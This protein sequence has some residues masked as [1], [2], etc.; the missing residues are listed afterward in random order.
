MV[1]IANSRYARIRPDGTAPQGRGGTV[2]LR[3]PC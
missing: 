1:Y 3:L 2:L